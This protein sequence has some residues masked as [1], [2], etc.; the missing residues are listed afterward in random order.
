MSLVTLPE[1]KAQLNMSSN[2][3]QDVALTAYIAAVDAI[4]ERH[5]GDTVTSQSF[6]ETLEV[7][8]WTNHLIVSK[9]PATALT[10]IATHDGG[11]TY[12]TTT[13]VLRSSG[14]IIL[15][16]RVFGLIDVTYTA[17]W[18]TA[19]ANY[20][21]AA[22]IIVQHL[23]KTRL[24]PTATPSQAALPDSMAPREVGYAIPNAALELLGR[25]APVVA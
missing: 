16:C 15:P 2:T 22:L 7:D 17:G 8:S 3:Q 25:R 4:V 24:G 23:W 12:D 20:A 10:S 18:K 19:P 14:V 1:V 6:T 13:A 11:T 5:T 21:Q 9:R